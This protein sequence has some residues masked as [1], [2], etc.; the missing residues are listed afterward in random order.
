MPPSMPPFTLFFLSSAFLV[1]LFDSSYSLASL[2]LPSSS[3]RFIRACLNANDPIPH[4]FI[5]AL[6]HQTNERML[7]YVQS[8]SRR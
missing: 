7:R 8:G 3:A 4:R 2:L 5:T 1:K 6:H